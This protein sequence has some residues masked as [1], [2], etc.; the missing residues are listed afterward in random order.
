M[1]RIRLVEIN[2]FRCIKSLTWFPSPGLN[3]LIGPGD[4]GKSTVLDAIDFCL[5]AHR[6][7]QITDADFYQLNVEQPIVISVTIGELDDDLKN[8]E[9]YGLYLRGFDAKSSRVNDEPGEGLET[10][11]TIRLTVTSDL[12]P[13]W[14]LVSERAEVQGQ[15]RKLKWVDCIRISPTRVGAYASYH[16][17]WGRGSILNRVSEE[18]ISSSAAL[19]NAIR[20][21]RNDFSKDVDGKLTQT[22]QVISSIA[23]EVGVAISGQAKVMLDVQSISFSGGSVS[24]HDG[25]GIPLRGLGTGST[26]LL[27]AGLQQKTALQS[28][29]ILV[30][31]L[32]YGLEPHRII[33]LL[34]FL[35]AKEDNPQLQVFIT[36]HSPVALRELSGDQLYVLRPIKERHEVLLVGTEDD[37]QGTIRRYPEAFLAKSVIICEGASEVGLIR[38]LD[39]YRNDNG[40][41]ITAQGVALVDCG[42][43]TPDRFL[44]RA[45][46]FQGLGYRTAIIRDSDV[47]PTK[48][49]ED[50]YI[51]RGGR[52]FACCGNRVLEDE[53]FMSLTKDGVLKLIDRAIDLKGEVLV[54]EQIKSSSKNVKDLQFIRN[55]ASSNDI[56]DDSRQILSKAARSKNDNS[57]FKSITSMENV[58]QDIVGPDL[59]NA[60]A[61]FKTSIENIF[62][63]ASNDCET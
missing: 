17:G 42:G 51:K 39:H 26:R 44:K 7:L 29:I 47:K 55:E 32:E 56:S 5:G 3:C 30:D 23:E 10:V 6:N 27:I 11:L 41:S 49:D 21:A 43:G 63:W 15:T 28:K 31:E 18:R 54:N 37:I 38:G 22:L 60:N 33:R 53:L 40:T 9:M 1:P 19:L 4:S 13:T 24:L 36:T 8:Y 46:A 25:D 57:W 12:E 34:N 61:D 45:N 2:N 52:V 14:S 62:K 59:E 50:D 48:N 16:L 35:C 20:E 58:A